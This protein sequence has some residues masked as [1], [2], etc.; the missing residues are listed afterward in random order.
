MLSYLR[1][2]FQTQKLICA[3]CKTNPASKYRKN[4]KLPNGLCS[5]CNQKNDRLSKTLIEPSAPTRIQPPREVKYKKKAIPANVKRL[6]W[7]EWIG[8][9]KGIGPCWCCRK[10]E[11]DK[12]SF[13]AGHV[14]PESKGGE[15]S[16]E[17]LRPVCQNCNTSMRD[18]N[19]LEF[20]DLYKLH[21]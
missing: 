12:A 16:V 13:H 4:G 14:K 17:N 20:I 9:E 1:S 18:M 15:A 6:V 10:T 21:K 7:D 5:R 8:R 2:F 11:I 19:M 3:M